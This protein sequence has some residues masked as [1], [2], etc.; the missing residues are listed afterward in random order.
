LV[1]AVTRRG[2]GDA[3]ELT[4]R[5]FR[6][7]HL[8]RFKPGLEKLGLAGLPDA[9]AAAQYHYL[10]NAIGGV[11]TEYMYESDRKAWIRYPPPRWI[12]QGTAICAIPG[13]VSAAMLRGWHAHNGVSLGNPRLGFVCTKQTVDGDPGL[14]GYYYE[15]DHALAPGDRLKLARN[16]DAPKFDPA[17]APSLPSAEW[18]A[19]RLRKAHRN[20][21]MEYVR[22]MI[23]E[24]IELF[25]PQQ[26]MELLGLTGRLI[27]MQFYQQTAAALGLPRS[28]TP[29]GFADFLMALARA[30]G[31]QATLAEDGGTFAVR[32]TT[33]SLMR[34]VRAHDPAA[35]AAWNALLEGA[36]MAHNRHLSLAVT[37]RLD[38]GDAA[39]A[40]RIVER[41]AARPGEQQPRG[42]SFAGPLR[43][44]YD[45]GRE[46]GGVSGNIGWN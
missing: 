12:W 35:F 24:A 25:G 10:S 3:A 8:E 42:L 20:Y 46:I 37:E 19:E 40:W 32:Q 2:A 36:L 26:A 21:A 4:F 29:K 5:I 30:Q 34:G 13:E 6:K 11:S 33:W 22:T 9:V 16:E 15:H 39:F 18:P 28:D 45:A 43:P 41:P 17:K 1:A 14:E 7:Q 27:G 38:L 23:P 31:D 44:Y